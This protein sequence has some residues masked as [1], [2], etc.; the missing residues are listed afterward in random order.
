MCKANTLPFIT[1]SVPQN[2]KLLKFFITPEDKLR[3]L[4]TAPYI[5][6][7]TWQSFL[8]PIY[9]EFDHL[10]KLIGNQFLMAHRV[11]VG[12]MGPRG[13]GKE[14][15][16]LANTSLRFLFQFYRG[17]YKACR[18]LNPSTEY[19]PVV[20]ISRQFQ[21]TLQSEKHYKLENWPN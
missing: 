12:R 16:I 20:K 19:L 13:N 5:S 21:F 15:N 9:Q 17:T 2:F 18:S 8:P 4:I 10:K 6:S 11:Y 14:D 7:T 1:S 3:T